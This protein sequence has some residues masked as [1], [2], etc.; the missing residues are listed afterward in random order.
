M[1]R[2]THVEYLEHIHVY[3]Y[4]VYVHLD[5]C[6][7]KGYNVSMRCT[8]CMFACIYIPVHVQSSSA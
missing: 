6:R 1:N 5:K 8:T 7:L 2:E 3:M 4:N